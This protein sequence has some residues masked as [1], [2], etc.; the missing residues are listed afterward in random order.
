MFLPGGIPEGLRI[1]EKSNWTGRGVVCP[2][3]IY[4]ESKNRDE[5]QHPGVYVLEGPSEDGELPTI[6]IGEGDPIRP[7]LDSHYARKDFWTRVIFF[8][9]KDQT[10]NKA[11]VQHLESRLITLAREAKRSKLDNEVGSNSPSLAEAELADVESFLSDMHSIFPLLGLP[12]FEK[13]SRQGRKDFMLYIKAKGIQAHGQEKPEGFV[14]FKGSEMISTETKSM[15]GFMKRLRR[16]L[17]EQGVVQ[18]AGANWVFTQDYSFSSPSYSAG[19]ILGMS[20]NGRT[21]WKDSGGRTLKAIQESKT[22][23]GGNSSA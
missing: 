23:E 22:V 8:T 20:A 11:H 9:S 1:V 2:R 21:E 4:T 10:L 6:Y 16:D 5:F 14:V 3:T 15:H 17:I 19:V 18:Q 7:R 12:V 13:P